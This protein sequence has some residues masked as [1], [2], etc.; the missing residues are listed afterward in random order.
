MIAATQ[1][2]RVILELGVLCA[3]IWVIGFIAEHLS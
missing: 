3:F 2:G 1:W